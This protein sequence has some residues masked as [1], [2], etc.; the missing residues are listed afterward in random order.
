MRTRR[1]T[2]FTGGDDATSKNARLG[3]PVSLARGPPGRAGLRAAVLE[4]PGPGRRPALGMRQG[5]KAALVHP[6]TANSQRHLPPS[7]GHGARCQG[8]GLPPAGRKGQGKTPSS[9]GDPDCCPSAVP[10]P[11]TH[12]AGHGAAWQTSCRLPGLLARSHSS[13][14]TGVL[15]AESMHTKRSS[16][17]PAGRKEGPRAPRGGLS[18]DHGCPTL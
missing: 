12:Q 7:T 11:R 15:R 9:L 2:S 16:I 8:S 14:R 3:P 1:V 4:G 17:R 18:K 6:H 5:D 13:S 10:L